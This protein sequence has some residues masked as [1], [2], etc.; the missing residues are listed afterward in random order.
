MQ[1]FD[2]S[3]SARVR[4]WGVDE[5]I[6]R[7]F[8]LFSHSGDSWIVCGVLLLVWAFVKGDAQ[9]ILAFW[10]LSIAI[11]AVFVLGLK[12]LIRRSRPDGEWGQ[13]YRRIDPYS[14]PSG[15]AV[16]GGLIVALAWGFLPAWAAVLLTIWGGLMILSR[17]VTGVHYLSDVLAG[18][19]L[20]LFLGVGL[21]AAS[22][23]IFATFPVL[24]DRDLWRDFLIGLL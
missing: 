15:H 2:E 18:T 21:M 10:G 9:R 16:R 1:S 24:F 3:A 20:G 23:W 22:G 7:V 8:A 4:S 11:V 12:A 13:V 14:F 6:F 5:R 19:A 17:V